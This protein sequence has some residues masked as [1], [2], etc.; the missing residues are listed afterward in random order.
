MVS[1]RSALKQE[2]TGLVKSYTVADATEILKNKVLTL[3]DP[4]TAAEVSATTNGSGYVCAGIASMDKEA[5]DGS[6]KISVWVTGDFNVRASGTIV[7]GQPIKSCG[8][9]EFRAATASD[10]VS[11]V[12]CGYA[13]DGVST[14]ETFQL[15][16]M[17]A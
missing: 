6:T 17:R 2:G 13:L 14:K 12:I 1:A 16:L 11:G 3:S 9:G 8:D 10:V 5:D 15:R 4:R 7:T